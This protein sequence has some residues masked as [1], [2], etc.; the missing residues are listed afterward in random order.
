MRKEED[1]S[2]ASIVG[3]TIVVILGMAVLGEYWFRQ[4]FGESVS[5]APTENVNVAMQ[6]KDTLNQMDTFCVNKMLQ[7]QR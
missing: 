2:G 6:G 7:K 1:V 4:C 3:A 5:V